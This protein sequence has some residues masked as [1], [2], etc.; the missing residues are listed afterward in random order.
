MMPQAPH[1][2][3]NPASIQA[4]AAL[5]QQPLRT[6]SFSQSGT[7]NITSVLFCQTSTQDQIMQLLRSRILFAALTATLLLGCQTGTD[8][9]SPDGRAPVRVFLLLISTKQ[10][11]YYRWA[12]QT[13]EAR[14][15]NVDIIIEQFPGSSL[16]DFE[17]KL[18]LRFSSGQAP[19]VFF[20]EEKVIAEYARLGLLA[21]APPAIEKMVQ[22][23]SINA[24]TRQAPYIDGTCYGITSASVWTVLYYNKQM[25][26]EAGLDPEQPPRTWD[27]L[28]DYADRL[29][30]RRPDGTPERAGF[31]LRKT[32]FKPGTAGKWFTFLYAAGGQPFTAD[33]TASAFNSEAGRAALDLYHTILFEKQIDAV[34]LEGDQQGFGQGRAAMFIREAHVVPWLAEHYPD[35]DFGVAPIPAQ[36][37]SL[38]A[39]GSYLWVV[40]KDSPQQEAAWGFIE[41]LMSDDAYNRY[42]ALGLILPAT[43]SVAAQ[44]RYRDDP[45]Y[46]VFLDQQVAPPTTHPR[47]G[48]AEDIIGGYIERFCYGHIGAE[49]MLERAQHDVDALL[50]RNR[51]QEE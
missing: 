42:T 12:E 13:Y 25:F 9:A 34:E 49:E 27:E 46:S 14:H 50:A 44:P 18:R 30:V 24:M 17:I 45:Y 31:S 23:N 7:F 47:V 2:D 22:E 48:R 32:G 29:T 26:R 6:R 33:G 21:P 40:S 4:W 38:S 11:E 37:T 43:R 3:R 28:I 41:F 5:R 19:D 8:T 1:A 16:K 20:A 10:V 15:P 36:A 35:L 39:G 51:R